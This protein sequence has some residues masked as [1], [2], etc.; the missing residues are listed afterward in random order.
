MLLQ[1]VTMGGE[2]DWARGGDEATAGQH[3]ACAA[4]TAGQPGA[5]RP[6]AGAP[7][8]C[9]CSRPKRSRA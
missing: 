6:Q 5:K 1:E 9:G 2:G 3:M 4:D 8:N 7:G